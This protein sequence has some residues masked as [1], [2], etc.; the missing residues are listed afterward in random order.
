[1]AEV[2]QTGPLTQ[3][4]LPVVSGFFLE[5]RI[6]YDTQIRQMKYC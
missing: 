2:I 6:E 3:A 1:M 4:V 5:T